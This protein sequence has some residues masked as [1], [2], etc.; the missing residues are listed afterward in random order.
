MTREY[1]RSV[2]EEVIPRARITKGLHHKA[3][4]PPPR[5]ALIWPLSV[6]PRDALERARGERL[7]QARYVSEESVE[8][9]RPNHVAQPPRSHAWLEVRAIAVAL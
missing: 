2:K 7:R 3:K 4:V 5:G 9:D 8:I 6:Q 1:L